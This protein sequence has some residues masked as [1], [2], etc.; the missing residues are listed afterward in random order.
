PP[1]SREE[2][3]HPLLRGEDEVAVWPL[4]EDVLLLAGCLELRVLGLELP[5]PEE[6]LLDIRGEG[7]RPDE[8]G[9][10]QAKCSHGDLQER[11]PSPAPGTRDGQTRAPGFVEPDGWGHGSPPP[12]AHRTLIKCSVSCV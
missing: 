11:R 5:H 8:Q 12:V 2:G 1:L 10:E 4:A 9:T 3:H 6:L 7:R